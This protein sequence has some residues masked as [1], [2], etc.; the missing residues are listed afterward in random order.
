MHSQHL[1][2]ITHESILTIRK[3][4]I[5][6]DVVG[7]ALRRQVR[8]RSDAPELR[9]AGMGLEVDIVHH[10]GLLHETNRITALGGD[11]RGLEAIRHASSFGNQVHDNHVLS[12]SLIS[13]RSDGILNHNASRIV[14]PRG[15]I[16]ALA[17]ATHANV[18]VPSFSRQTR[19]ACSACHYQFPQLTPFGRLF[20]LNGYTLT[21]LSTIGEPTDT[22]GGR[23][24]LSLSPIPPVATMVVASLTKTSRAQPGLQNNTTSFPQQASIFLAGHITPSIGTFAQFTYTAV[25]GKIGIGNV[26]VRYAKHTALGDRDVLLG[27]TLHNNPTVQD[28]WNTTPA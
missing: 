8:T 24:S 2:R 10:A 19:L 20:K 9:V 13:R 16:A 21:G 4:F 5:D 27:V 12:A 15:F 17:V 3:A 23:Q 14:A 6:D 26:D 22:A 7:L 1:M 28:V 11:L 18:T 25:D